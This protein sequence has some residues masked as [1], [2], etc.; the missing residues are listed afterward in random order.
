MTD[1]EFAFLSGFIR[2]RSGLDLG[3]EKRYLVESRLTPLRREAGL[4]TLG[5]IVHALRR[6]DEDLARSVL[7][8]VAT[9]ETLFF[10]DRAPFE[11]LR[12]TILPRLAASR[13][14]GQPLRIWSAAASTGQEAYSL[15]MLV[16]EMADVLRGR[17]VEILATDLSAVAIGRARAGLYTQFE[18]Q[19]GLP[20]RALLLHFKQ[21]EGGWEI[22]PELRQAVNF[23]PFNLLDDFAGLGSFDVI[24]CRNLLIYFDLPGKE[25]LL[26]KLAQALAPDGFLSLGAAETTLGL[27]RMLVPHPELRG[28]FVHG[29]LPAG[30]RM[31]SDLSASPVLVAAE[32]ARS[33]LAVRPKAG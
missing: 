29:T 22:R 25:K 19:R 1:A 26:A 27:S 23:R 11:G 30:S 16:R 31:R 2:S 10:R 20:I 5:D 18:V 28:F 33:G 8:A 4:G 24:L 17:S 7:E 32:R 12:N 15:A 3:P 21:H 13:P 6:G 14:P 9:H